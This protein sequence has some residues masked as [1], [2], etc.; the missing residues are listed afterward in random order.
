MEKESWRRNRRRE[1]IEEASR[2]HI[3]GG[4]MED[5]WRGNHRGLWVH[6]EG[7]WETSGTQKA[8]RRDPGGTQETPRRHTGGTQKAPRQTG[9]R[10]ETEATQ[11]APRSGDHGFTC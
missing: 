4:L 7:N 6:Q 9:D 11:E 1:S 10:Q 5:S 2:G 8:S 3:M